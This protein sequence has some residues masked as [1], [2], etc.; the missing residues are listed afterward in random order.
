MTDRNRFPGPVFFFHDTTTS[1]LTNCNT[2]SFER[3]IA[4]GEQVAP[5]SIRV[6][7]TEDCASVGVE[8]GGNF[9]PQRK[10][11][12]GPWFHTPQHG[13]EHH[14]HGFVEGEA[15]H[16]DCGAD[17]THEATNHRGH[18]GLALQTV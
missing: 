17:G 2:V 7:K 8:R 10:Y 15:I 4:T 1:H 9:L 16:V 5:Q 18:V 6:V 13:N 11:L 12:Q 3:C 14:G